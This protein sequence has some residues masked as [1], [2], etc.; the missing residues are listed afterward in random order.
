MI[1]EL[2]YRAAAR[3]GMCPLRKRRTRSIVRCVSSSGSFYGNTVI[4]ALIRRR[5]PSPA[6]HVAPLAISAEVLVRS[7]T[8]T[9]LTVGRLWS[10]SVSIPPIDRN[11]DSLTRKAPAHYHQ[12]DVNLAPPFVSG[13]RAA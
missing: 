9:A 6:R 10:L 2:A 5:L 7:R 3:I 4:T 13:E 12:A 11:G 1:G 8:S